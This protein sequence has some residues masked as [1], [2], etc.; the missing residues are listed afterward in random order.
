V[1][2]QAVRTVSGARR[3]SLR[4]HLPILLTRPV[5]QCGDLL[6]DRLVTFFDA[7]TSPASHAERKVVPPIKMQTT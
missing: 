2:H 5:A 1:F 6:G 3:C 7:G 4:A